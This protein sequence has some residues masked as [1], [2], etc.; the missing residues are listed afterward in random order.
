[1]GNNP[2][3][4]SALGDCIVCVQ[5]DKEAD[6][7]E[8]QLARLR[9]ALPPLPERPVRRLHVHLLNSS[10]LEED[11]TALCEA[12]NK[13]LVTLLRT[14]H[15]IQENA[16]SHGFL[17]VLAIIADT[18]DSEPSR[19]TAGPPL[20][21]DPPHPHHSHS[22]RPSGT[23]RPAYRVEHV[24]WDNCP[25]DF[26]AKRLEYYISS[27]WRSR[28]VA[29]MGALLELSVHGSHAHTIVMRDRPIDPAECG[30]RVSVHPIEA[31]V[32][33]PSTTSDG[34]EASAASSSCDNGREKVDEVQAVMDFCDAVS[35]KLNADPYRFITHTFLHQPPSTAASALPT[36]PSLVTVWQRSATPR[37]YCVQALDLAS[38]DMSESDGWL[39]AV[40][41]MM[42]ECLL[43]AE[44][45]RRMIAADRLERQREVEG[46]VPMP[47]PFPEA[48]PAEAMGRGEGKSDSSEEGDTGEDKYR[49][50]VC[51]LPTP[52]PLS[53]LLPSAALGLSSPHH[54]KQHP[55]TAID[56]F[57]NEAALLAVYERVV[58]DRQAMPPMPLSPRLRKT[59][60]GGGKRGGGRVS[61]C[62]PLGLIGT[63]EH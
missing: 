62:E 18:A 19:S 1:M 51:L 35:D 22:S 28:G 9:A 32:M 38:F 27:A 30:T 43:G 33:T 63:R 5:R 45:Q 12:P 60:G 58:T 10:R 42:T 7:D 59:A 44:E 20:L 41:D 40:G 23:L 31:P 14:P 17:D 2:S 52:P 49:R 6:A 54:T 21:T 34:H 50:F 39:G 15:F 11:L 29:F 57:A 36:M 8:D 24:E 46:V 3:L 47:M 4:G 13:V 16:L 48:A 37:Q 25:S 56:L 53:S 26:F 61:F 55:H